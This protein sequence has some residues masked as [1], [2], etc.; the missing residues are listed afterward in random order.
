MPYSAPLTRA[1]GMPTRRRQL[2]L[3]MSLGVGRV[4]VALAHRRLRPSLSDVLQSPHLSRD[5]GW[6][7][8]NRV[9]PR[10]QAE[11]LRHKTLW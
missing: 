9:S 7:V 8:D 3:W 5:I 11:H 4:R 6:D 2:R 10:I 1:A